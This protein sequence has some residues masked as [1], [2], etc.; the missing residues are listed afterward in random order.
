MSL[1]TIPNSFM[2]NSLNYRFPVKDSH[3]L[4]SKTHLGSCN[5]AEARC[6]RP[7][8]IGNI[9]YMCRKVE[10]TIDLHEVFRLWFDP[11][12]PSI[13][14]WCLRLCGPYASVF[15]AENS[16]LFCLPHSTAMASAALVMSSTT[17]RVMASTTR[18]TST[19]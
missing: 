9:L 2:H 6:K 14:I 13:L 4:F 17:P 8:L 15:S 1:I 12:A 7:S 11:L 5:C 10:L 18:V 19:E 16:S 3:G